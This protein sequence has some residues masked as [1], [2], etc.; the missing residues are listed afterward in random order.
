MKTERHAAILDIIQSKDIET[1]ED[2][3][4]ELRNHNIAVTQAT[5]SRDIK[6]LRLIK[7]MGANK[8][9]KYAANT[10]ANAVQMERL[11]RLFKEST[12]SVDAASN[13]I[14]IKTLSGSANAA[15]SVV[16]AMHIT[17]I[18]GC[19]AGDDTILVILKEVSQVE[20]ALQQFKEMMK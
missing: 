10:R 20:S 9:Y 17:G 4:E 1:Q 19:I 3:A 8:R 11:V 18:I 7:V 14:V 16:D 5:V 13:L 6:E 15:A 2:L 12:V